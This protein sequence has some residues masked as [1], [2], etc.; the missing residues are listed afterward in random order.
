MLLDSHFWLLEEK[1]ITPG[2]AGSDSVPSEQRG[3]QL[4]YILLLTLMLLLSYSKS[5]RAR[6][7]PGA[8]QL[9]DGRMYGAPP[10]A[11]LLKFFQ[12]A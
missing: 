4:E 12:A 7:D 6:I 10:P 5:S 9:R 3:V 1:S 11:L 8:E 2:V